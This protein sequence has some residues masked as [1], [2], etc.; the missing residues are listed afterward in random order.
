[1]QHKQK[2]KVKV[3]AKT[4]ENG[5]KK[6]KEKE[7][8]KIL[9]AKENLEEN[10][11]EKLKIKML[12]DPRKIVLIGC[13]EEYALV[14]PNAAISMMKA[15]KEVDKVD[16]TAQEDPHHQDTES[17]AQNREEA[18]LRLDSLTDSL[19]IIGCKENAKK[20]INAITTMLARAQ[21]GKREL[22][23]MERNAFGCIEISTKTRKWV[24]LMLM[25]HHN[26][27]DP[28]KAT[29]KETLPRPKPKPKVSL[30][31]KVAKGE[32]QF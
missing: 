2:A 6:K 13:I 4:K 31:R 11:K 12:K 21:C 17:Q 30:R 24:L 10:H 5:K 27:K 23:S 1:M 28:Q 19:A 18:D 25:L 29:P 8:A 22:V 15:R 26:T 7:K 32:W 16:P 14:A 3:K 9:K 20:E